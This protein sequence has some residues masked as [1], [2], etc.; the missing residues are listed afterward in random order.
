M[1]GVSGSDGQQYLQLSGAFTVENETFYLDALQNISSVYEMRIQQQQSFQKIYI[2]M[3]LACALLTYS[4]AWLLTRPLVKLSKAAKEIAKGNLSY[5]SRIKTSDEIGALS[6]DFDY[7]AS[8]TEKSVS[9]LKDAM[10]RQERFTRNFTHELKTPMASIIGYADLLRLQSLT[11]D[12]QAEAANY[13]FSEGKRLENLSLR[14]LELFVMDKQELALRDTSIGTLIEK[15][16]S[17]QQA[18]LAKKQ[19][20]VSIRCESGTCLMEPD[21]IWS[22]LVNLI[23]NA[24]K[25]L[26]RGGKL[27]IVSEMTAEGCRIRVADNGRGIPPETLAHI[28]EAFYRWDKVRSREENG[29]G[30]GLALCAK[31]VELHHGTIT[32]DSAV[33]A[34]TC[35]TVELKEGRI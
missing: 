21:L 5:R 25:A 16:V 34:G 32:F 12:E 28:T 23:D 2:A 29:T 1:S 11:P 18:I 7:M 4:I 26:E 14:L 35:V 27:G 20:E 8:Q 24:Q 15:V 13:I 10:S 31:I 30:L 3:V 19:I 6:V 9:D 22:L 17:S 33:G